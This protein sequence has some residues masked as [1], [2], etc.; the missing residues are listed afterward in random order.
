MKIIR[1]N[2]KTSAEEDFLRNARFDPVFDEN[3]NL[4]DIVHL[5]VST[6]RSQGIKAMTELAESNEPGDE[7]IHQDGWTGKQKRILNSLA[8]SSAHTIKQSRRWDSSLGS[9]VPSATLILPTEVIWTLFEKVFGSNYSFEIKDLVAESEDVLGSGVENSND[10]PGRI[11][12]ARA[13]VAISIH[14]A[15]GS[16][17]IFEGMGVAHDSLKMEATG[18][19][20][21]INSAR[22]TAEKGA[23][24]DAKREAL[25]NMG[26]VFRR[27]FE[28]GDK[29]LKSI[30]DKLMKIISKNN[31]SPER[32]KV[33]TV[34]A[35][36]VKKEKPVKAKTVTKPIKEQKEKPFKLQVSNKN[37]TY[38]TP[39]EVYDATIG[40]LE[41]LNNIEE[42]KVFLEDNKSTLL[43]AEA[44]SELGDFTYQEIVE[45]V[46]LKDSTEHNDV[47]KTTDSENI[48][49]IKLSGKKTGKAIISAYKEM[50]QKSTSVDDMNKISDANQKYTKE[51]TARQKTELLKLITKRQL[52]L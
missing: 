24:S 34:A 37:F 48:W 28:D 12:Y 35:P 1:P 47:T 20:F 19:T 38:N 2:T 49:E 10:H 25:G 23:I 3:G 13:R 17:R 26:R 33:K 16:V 21:S 27:A 39:F 7:V 9:H 44:K 36:E 42:K 40:F 6:D 46:E 51:L 22:R 15:N 45:M 29:A 41:D 14:L 50:L 4:V 32:V 52:E 31:P 5:T 18:N 8:P 30:E 11:F 43:E